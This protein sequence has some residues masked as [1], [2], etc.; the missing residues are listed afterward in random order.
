MKFGIFDHMDRGTVPLGAQYES[1]LKLVEAYDAGGFHAYHLAEHHA[2]PLGMAPS[3][4]VFLGAVAQ[5]TRRLR[6]GP[7]VY[8]LPLYHPMRVYEEICMLDNMSGGRLEL[9][10]GRGAVPHE[11]EHYSIAPSE[12]QARYFETY[13]ILMKAFASKT[14]N[15]TG[16][17]YSFRDVPLE[18]APVQKPHP[19][20]WYGVSQP[21]ATV[22]AA[23][24][25]LNVVVNGPTAMVRGIVER[26]RSEWTQAGRDAAEIPF[27]AMNR[28]IVI[29]ESDKEAN[30]IAERGYKV[31]RGN[32]LSLWQRHGTTPP[33]I[34]A[35]YGNTFEELQARGQGFAGSPDTV[36]DALE[37]QVRETGVNY[38]M[39]R[40]AFGDLS[41]DES[42]R[43]VEQFVT[44]VMPA[45]TGLR[46]AA[47]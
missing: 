36:R 33:N 15:H 23:Q 18:I 5:R 20:L 8:T 3:P 47:E 2:T 26:Y 16:T 46:Q 28:H 40:F 41:F 9:G 12:G 39:C 38:L 44:R 19:P 45:L 14:L 1:R 10:V 42:H 31:W 30:N 13:D 29:A 21:E 35:L 7:L 24:N 17:F 34:S 4:S 25:R 27:M 32:F 22:W 11:I 6:F 43:S 37:R